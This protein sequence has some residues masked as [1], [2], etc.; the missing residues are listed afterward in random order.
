MRIG[1]FIDTFYPMV[2]GVIN[3]V[4]NYARELLNY[5]EVT[6]FCP[7]VNDTPIKNK[8]YKIIQCKSVSVKG[9]DYAIPLPSLD[10][11]FQKEL[12]KCKLDVIH[13]HSPFMLGEIGKNYAKRKKIPLLATIHSQFRQDFERAV[14]GKTAVDFMTNIIMNVFNACDLC[15]ALNDGMKNLYFSEYGLTAPC[16]IRQNA[17]CHTPIENLLQANEEINNTYSLKNNQPVFLFVGRINYLKGV[18]LIVKSLKI[19]KDKQIDFKMIFAGAGQ[20]EDALNKLIEA[21]SLNNEVILTGKITDVSLLEKLYAR[22]T[23]F[24]FPSLYDANSL[25]QIESACQSTPAIFSR[26]AITASQ[27]TDGEN[28]FLADY[29]PES[30]ADKIIEVLNNDHLYQ[31]VCSNAKL[32]LYQVWETVVRQTYEDYLILINKSKKEQFS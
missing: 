26:G 4:D 19:L 3:V 25:V 17:T 12:E 28:G 20:D 6:V 32:E 15:Y 11:K 22:A 18:D 9:Y 21:L 29:T 30:F 5:G 8:P 27:I 7:L 14:K 1:L 31:K 13:I 2:D 10:P 24:L 23:L 16:K